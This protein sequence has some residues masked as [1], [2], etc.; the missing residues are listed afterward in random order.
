MSFLVE[1]DRNSSPCWPRATGPSSTKPSLNTDTL[2]IGWNTRTQTFELNVF[3]FFLELI[4]CY[5]KSHVKR[6]VLVG[7]T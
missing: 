3:C 6:D 2:R 1:K 7:E 4:L 5:V